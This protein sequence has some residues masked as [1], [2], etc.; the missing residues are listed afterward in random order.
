M[1]GEENSQTVPA[2]DEA[3]LTKISLSKV[4][5]SAAT[6]EKI[7]SIIEKLCWIRS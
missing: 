5:I 4:G 7:P 1:V 3:R 6:G 2:I